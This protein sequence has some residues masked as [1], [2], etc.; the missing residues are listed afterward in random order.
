LENAL[1]PLYEEIIIILC[2]NTEAHL[3]DYVP[4]CII[5]VVVIVIVVVTCMENSKP[6]KN[7]IWYEMQG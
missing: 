5:V 4:T 1:L 2:K 3:K 7:L 6:K